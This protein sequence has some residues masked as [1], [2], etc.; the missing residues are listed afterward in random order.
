MNREYV[1]ALPPDWWFRKVSYFIFMVR[2]LTSLAVAAYAV[3]LLVLVASAADAESFSELYEALRSP[4]SVVL[5]LIV[6]LPV[7]LHAVT[8]INLMPKSLAIRLGEERV[9]ELFI[10]AGGFAAWIGVSLVV[11]FLALR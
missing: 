3:F 7:L 8:W 10:A 5:H 9:P 11:A 1:G 4:V 2:E 6:L